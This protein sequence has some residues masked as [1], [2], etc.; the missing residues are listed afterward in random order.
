MKRK[1]PPPFC[2]GAS[3]NMYQDYYTGKLQF[4]KGN[5][6]VFIGAKYQRGHGLGNIL[7][8]LF[9]SIILPFIKRNA[10]M[11]AGKAIKT[12]INLAGD[13]SRGVPFKQS[14]KRQLPKALKEAADEVKFQSG[15]G[16]PKS[17][18]RRVARPRR[19]RRRG[20]GGSGRSRQR[21]NDIF[22]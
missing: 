22:A 18:H 2:C 12:G 6:P 13:A 3:R 1:G 17:K 16:A 20:G 19:R 5:M 15:S 10:P 11:I 14:V 21:Y 4:G 7:S 9:R 8:G